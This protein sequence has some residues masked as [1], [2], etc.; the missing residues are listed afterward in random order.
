M[1]WRRVVKR[2][3]QRQ[4]AKAV[5]AMVGA[6]SG[7]LR[8]DLLEFFPSVLSDRRVVVRTTSGRHERQDEKY[9]S[10]EKTT[11]GTGQPGDCAAH[12]EFLSLM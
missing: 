1:S 4:A 12:D 8:G 3:E 6:S 11:G 2:V 10:G 7:L 9:C 5:A